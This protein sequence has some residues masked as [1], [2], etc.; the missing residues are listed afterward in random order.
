MRAVL[1]RGLIILLEQRPEK[2]S[3]PRHLKAR[4]RGKRRGAHLWASL[5]EWAAHMAISSPGARLQES[6]APGEFV[7]AL[8]DAHLY[9]DHVEQA[10]LQL[11][12]APRPLPTMR[13]NPAVS[14]LF[15][16]RYEDFVLEDYNPHPH[17]KAKVAV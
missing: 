8:R 17:I 2:D 12:R 7:H 6:G 14:D 11:T 5:F 4:A 13:F 1:L 15:A 16:F 10:R 3:R 9:I